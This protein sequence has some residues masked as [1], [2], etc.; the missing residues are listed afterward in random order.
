MD[1]RFRSFRS[2]EPCGG[3]VIHQLHYSLSGDSF[4]VAS[5]AAQAKLLDRDGFEKAEFIKGD[6]YLSDLNNTKY[7]LWYMSPINTPEGTW[8]LLLLLFGIQ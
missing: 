5:G 6:M 3:H 2:C 7:F 8:L 4:L 1:Q